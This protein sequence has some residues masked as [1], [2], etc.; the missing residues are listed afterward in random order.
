MEMSKER[1]KRIYKLAYE[2]LIEI[3]GVNVVLLEKYLAPDPNQKANSME[4]VFKRLIIS[5][6]NR[7]MSQNVILKRINNVSGEAEGLRTVLFNFNHEKVLEKYNNDSQA[8]LTDIK[9]TTLIEGIREEKNS[10]WP[11]FCETIL[12]VA[13][14]LSK[15]KNIEDL[16]KWFKFFDDDSRSRVALPMIISFEIKGIGFALACD[17][18]KEIGYTGFGKPDVHIKAIFKE[19]NIANSTDDY[20]VF[21]DIVSFSNSVEKNSYNVD[22]LFWLCATRNFYNDKINLGTDR[23]AFLNYMKKELQK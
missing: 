7:Q 6:A 23:D 19:L 16:S 13:K 15:F 22:K 20:S 1:N 9:K 12:S 4:N 18:L 21:N 5:S 2:Y 10:L 3:P 11:K 14:F 17:F 8:L